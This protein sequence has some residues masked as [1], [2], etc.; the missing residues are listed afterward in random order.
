MKRVAG[1]CRRRKKAS[2][3]KLLSQPNAPTPRIDTA[4]FVV[5]LRKPSLPW[6]SET[7]INH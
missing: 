7:S 3:L 2:G 1:G 6:I 4:R 5:I